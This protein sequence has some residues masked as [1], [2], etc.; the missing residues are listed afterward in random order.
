LINKNQKANN[1]TTQNFLK[2]ATIE[3]GF[4]ILKGGGVRLILMCTPL[5]FALK[6]EAEQNAIIAEYQN[7]LNALEFPIQILIQSKT[8][9]LTSYL[10]Q[11][12]ERRLAAQNPLLERQILDYM[13]FI[14]KLVQIANI[15]DKKFFIII[16]WQNPVTETKGFLA[17][18]RAASNQK[19]PLDET[20][21]QEAKRDLTE[22]AKVV[23]SALASMGIQ[24]VQLNTKE[25]IELFYQTYNPELSLSQKLIDPQSLT[26][27]YISREK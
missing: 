24:A 15:V 21:F 1:A 14:R 12:E 19:I 9:D 8:V 26:S 5:N 18:F 17:K 11:L 4:V 16:S 25:L 7:F 2:I 6:S 23:A 10:Q 20:K 13:E 22:K 3:D 27:T